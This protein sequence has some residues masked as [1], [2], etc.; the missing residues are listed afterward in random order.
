VSASTRKSP[1]ACEKTLTRGREVFALRDPHCSVLYCRSFTLPITHHPSCA[2]C[3]NNTC[4]PSLAM[5]ECAPSVPQNGTARPVS[6]LRHRFTDQTKA[7]GRFARS[8]QRPDPRQLGLIVSPKNCASSVGECGM[9]ACS[10]S[11]ILS[12]ICLNCLS[13][14]L[15]PNHN[16]QQE[17]E[18]RGSNLRSNLRSN[19]IG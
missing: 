9:F 7:P 16:H 19:V 2:N 3:C 13:Q 5:S 18:L 11:V 10:S 17:G 14:P 6:F 1:P 8:W 15:W 4:L 12:S